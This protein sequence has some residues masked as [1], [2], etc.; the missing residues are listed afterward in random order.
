MGSNMTAD[1]KEIFEVRPFV[2]NYAWGMRD[3]TGD[4]EEKIQEN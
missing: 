4:V 3:G 1:Q 2:Q